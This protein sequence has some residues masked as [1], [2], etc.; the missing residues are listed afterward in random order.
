MTKVGP[1]SSLVHL[2]R[3]QRPSEPYVLA[4][5]LRTRRA[6]HCAAA[7]D[8]YQPEVARLAAEAI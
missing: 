7:F 6:W 4:A 1:P 2:G 3:M 5:A 8:R